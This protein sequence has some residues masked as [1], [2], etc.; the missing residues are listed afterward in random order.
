MSGDHGEVRIFLIGQAASLHLGPDEPQRTHARVARIREDQLA[1][2]TR[3]HHLF[4][5]NIGR[6]PGQGQILFALADD[7]VRRRKRDKVGKACRIH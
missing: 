4:I 2:T 6:G 1:G 5:N 7:L 3:R